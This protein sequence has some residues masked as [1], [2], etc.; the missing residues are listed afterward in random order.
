MQ[1]VKAHEAE[2]NSVEWSHL[3]KRQVLTTSNDMKVKVWDAAA[4]MA[5]QVEEVPQ[6]LRVVR[7]SRARLE[8]RG[9]WVRVRLA[10]R[11]CPAQARHPRQCDQ[12][13][14]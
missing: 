7:A 13:R 3:N 14:P 2:V 4:G 1:V 11:Q 9:R 8:R 10:A 5:P 6:G 12:F